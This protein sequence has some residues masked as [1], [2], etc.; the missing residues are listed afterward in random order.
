MRR[1]TLSLFL[2]V[3]MV[4]LAIPAAVL[5]A[6]A[7]AATTVGDGTSVV[8]T[9]SLSN[10]DVKIADAS[11]RPA[12]G[13]TYN[14]PT[15]KAAWEVGMMSPTT[16]NEDYYTAN[17]ASNADAELI[18]A[19][20]TTSPRQTK[21]GAG[22]Q[23]NNGRLFFSSS[24][25]T[26]DG[27]RDWTG[28][29]ANV[30]V[31]YTAEYTGTI[32][33]DVSTLQFTRDW[34][35]VFCILLDGQPVGQFAAEGFDYATGAGWYSPTGKG[36]LGEA[37][38]DIQDVI[39]LSVQAGQKV[40]FVCRGVECDPAT[41]E[42]Q[43]YSFDFNHARHSAF[44]WNF[45]VSYTQ[46]EF[47]DE[48]ASS[49]TVTSNFSVAGDN[50]DSD[51]IF[52]GGIGSIEQSGAWQ[53]G[54]LEVNY[55]EAT[56]VLTLGDT[57][58]AYD[59][60]T[61]AG[62]EV[63]LTYNEKVSNGNNAGD[64]VQNPVTG[65]QYGGAIYLLPY[66]E[67]NSDRIRLFTG[68]NYDDNG[69]FDS[70]Y[71]AAAIRY[72]AA[73]SGNATVD[74][75]GVW[76]NNNPAGYQYLLILKNGEEIGRLDNGGADSGSVKVSVSAND[77]IDF[78]V[79]TLPEYDATLEG[80]TF[81]KTAA[82]RGMSIKNI[83]VT[84]A[85]PK[86]ANPDVS[87]DFTSAVNLV[88]TDA[89]AVNMTAAPLSVGGELGAKVS[90]NGAEM[91]SVVGMQDGDAYKFV[92]ADGINVSD[93]TATKREATL[94]QAKTDGVKIDYVLTQKVDGHVITS[95]TYSTTTD[96]M[97]TAYESDS[98]ATVA[99]LAKAIR[100]VAAVSNAVLN[101][102]GDISVA[103]KAITRAYKTELDTIYA[104]QSY[105]NYTGYADGVDPT[106][107][108]KYKYAFA[109]AT[110]NFGDKIS[111]V[112][113]IQANGNGD[114]TGIDQSNYKLVETTQNYETKD[115]GRVTVEGVTY[116]GVIVDI[117]VALYGNDLSFKITDNAG[118]PVSATLTYNVKVWCAKT[119][120]GSCSSLQQGELCV[121]VYNLGKC[122][123][124]YTAAHPNA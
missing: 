33:I 12:K 96:A 24:Y 78:V 49:S 102:F 53:M 4:A 40:D 30:V 48:D 93:L 62:T 98:D 60:L 115:F 9:A 119:Y 5:P 116:M 117:P 113:L 10:A 57:F 26:V 85:A 54:S 92:L 105:A 46:Y 63:F 69:V 18:T 3:V 114:F 94:A 123:A 2:A 1:R 124:A 15:N 23:V 89:Y 47:V 111:L 74:V 108:T 19:S 27:V 20:A 21:N 31:R 35:S 118:N 68:I 6:V 122:A 84:I 36:D 82:K 7:A 73:Y 87:L 83:D 76:H 29:A 91:T 72:V 99:N 28:L 67:T 79:I 66:S 34:N 58:L 8:Y 70:Y 45:N 61:T 51:A 64:S 37:A 88:I 52:A 95:K 11:A 121:A 97:L 107:A 44:N 77:T 81:N 32:N 101:R 59:K 90:V 100:G 112:F 13:A 65:E 17:V 39:S 120:P 110:V 14:Y 106:D 38:G 109:G 22:F 42:A 80:V 41:A 56:G 75:T 86:A 25:E 71:A 16:W 104:D 50:F 55:D 43:G 103:E